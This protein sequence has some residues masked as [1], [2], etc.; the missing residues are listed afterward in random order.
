MSERVKIEFRVVDG[1]NVNVETPWA[2]RRVHNLYELD[3]TP[4]Y[5][6]NVSWK[7]VIEALHAADGMLEFKKISRK[8]G[9]K[10][11]RVIFDPPVNKSEA[12]KT[13]LDGM[14]DMGCYVEGANP[15]YIAVDIPP[16]VDLLKVRE[17]LI[18]AKVQWEHADPSY[19]LLF[20]ESK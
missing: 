14:V 10:T 18:K 13:I 20:P 2:K 8:S 12:S 11:V 16:E 9:H 6:Y 5:A 3:N 7:V 4:F 15:A 1:D 19:D 17:Y